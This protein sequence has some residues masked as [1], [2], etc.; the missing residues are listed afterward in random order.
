MPK[1]PYEIQVTM[2]LGDADADATA[3][4]FPTYEDALAWLHQPD[5]TL[6]GLL[7]WTDENITQHVT[8]RARL[9]RHDPDTGPQ[10]IRYYDDDDLDEIAAGAEAT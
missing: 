9:V 2:V 10:V 5:R 3:A 1:L 8:W 4:E 7:E 6:P